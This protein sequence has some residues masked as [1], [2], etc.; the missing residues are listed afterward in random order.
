M[1][2]DARYLRF[3]PKYGKLKNVRTLEL[4]SKKDRTRVQI[5]LIKETLILHLKGH[6]E[7]RNY[8][9][10]LSFEHKDE[11]K[12]VLKGEDCTPLKAS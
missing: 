12:S 2:K 5:D 10:S 8:V 3:L 11:T 9:R 7:Y 4:T 1:K 6:R